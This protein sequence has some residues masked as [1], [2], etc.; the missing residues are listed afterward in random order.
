ME[1]RRV[2]STGRSPSTALH[3]TDI[4]LC[5]LYSCHTKFTPSRPDRPARDKRVSFARRVLRG[6]EWAVSSMPLVWHRTNVGFR[7][8]DSNIHP[9]TA[10]PGGSS[11]QSSIVRGLPG[12]HAPQIRRQGA[13]L[14]TTS[15]Q[16]HGGETAQLFVVCR[17][18]VHRYGTLSLP[19]FSRRWG[20]KIQNDSFS[21]EW[22]LRL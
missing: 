22:A 18:T 12:R 2:P 14:S 7:F 11:H 13:R 10:L 21:L 3:V 9:M 6:P 19:S 4:C 16:M 8:K 1:C 17:I 20:L 5:I 15:A